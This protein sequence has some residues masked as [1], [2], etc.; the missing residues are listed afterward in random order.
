[1]R[2]DPLFVT[3][4]RNCPECNNKRRRRKNC[5]AC[6]RTG[7]RKND[8]LEGRW[9]V[10]GAAFLVCG[11]PSLS[12]LDIEQLRGRGICSLAVNNAAGYAPVTAWTFSDPQYK[13]HH[14]CFLDPKLITFA[15]TPK[16]G[17][18]LRIKHPD[19]PDG[20]TFTDMRLADCPNTWGY[21]RRTLLDTDSFL[22]T[23]YAHWG[24]GGKQGEDRS[25]S[26]LNTMFCGLRL[27]HYMGA[28][29]IYL[30]GVDFKKEP[31]AFYAWKQEKG[32]GGAWK[33]SARLMERL[34]PHLEHHGV[35]VFNC[36]PTS[37]LEVFAHTPYNEALT[38]CR[39]PVP[40]EPFDLS[41]WYNKGPVREARKLHKTPDYRHMP[42][43]ETLNTIRPEAFLD[44]EQRGK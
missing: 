11:G 43:F 16:L 7:W 8:T 44:S 36:N 9:S 13:F 42:L 39:Y 28:R 24:W 26:A 12:T 29:T 27:V 4:N 25:F 2:T 18:H 30:L 15:P 5:E 41:G 20:F 22:T 33:K 38:A 10:P 23:D 19:Y 32:G 37:A 21:G 6:H 35:K 34:K 14:G 17:K 40:E 31:D 1:V 3:D